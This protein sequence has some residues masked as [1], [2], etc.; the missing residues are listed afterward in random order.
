[1]SAYLRSASSALEMLRPMQGHSAPPATSTTHQLAAQPRK[2]R[3]SFRKRSTDV[4]KGVPANHDGVSPPLVVAATATSGE[5][6]STRVAAVGVVISEATPAGWGDPRGHVERKKTSSARRP[7][8]WAA[9]MPGPTYGRRVWS[10]FPSPTE[11][12]FAP[13]TTLMYG[14][15]AVGTAAEA[16]VPQCR[17]QRRFREDSGVLALFL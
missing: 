14:R 3:L 7:A 16:C 1:M 10:Y 11:S 17:T 6:E 13:Q 2:V 9:N 5:G 8:I 4:E 12:R 15:R